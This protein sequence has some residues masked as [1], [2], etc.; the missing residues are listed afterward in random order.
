MLQ[1]SSL[2]R[3][4]C[5]DKSEIS[6]KSRILCEHRQQNLKYTNTCIIWLRKMLVLK[7]DNS[8]ICVKYK[9]E[10]ELKLNVKK[11]VKSGRGDRVQNTP[12]A[13]V[14]CVLNT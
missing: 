3:C 5:F 2:S 12:S 4:F 7:L 10:T 14:V 9:H 11:I 13:P 6:V 8:L 1:L